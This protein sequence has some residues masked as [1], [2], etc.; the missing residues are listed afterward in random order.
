VSS[1][2]ANEAEHAAKDH[3]PILHGP[4]WA[5]AVDGR[6][7]TFLLRLPVEVPSPSQGKDARPKLHSHDMPAARCFS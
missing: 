7:L 3:C 6:H 4:R 5:I 2:L 1:A